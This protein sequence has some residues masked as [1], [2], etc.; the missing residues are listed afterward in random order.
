METLFYKD[1]YKYWVSRNWFYRTKIVPKAPGGNDFVFL[2]LD[3]LL[4]IKRGYAWDGASGP[5][6]NT[7]DFIR[8]S[9][10]HDAL[11]QLIREGVL[12][13]DD[14]KD[15]DAILGEILHDDAI[16]LANKQKWPLRTVLK[17]IAS[18][19]PIWVEGAVRLFGGAYSAVNHDE[20]L[21]F[22]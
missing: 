17:M 3:G 21:S 2:T 15:A 8:A 11:Y 5:A 9:L 13:A 4:V 16:L 7:K 12:T 14:R 1:G 19:R 20:E 18:I 22:P 10:V 6:I